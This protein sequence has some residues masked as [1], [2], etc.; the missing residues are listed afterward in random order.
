MKRNLQ[1]RNTFKIEIPLIIKVDCL[2]KWISMRYEINTIH[3]NS[4]VIFNIL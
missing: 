4:G 3:N 1:L 2:Q